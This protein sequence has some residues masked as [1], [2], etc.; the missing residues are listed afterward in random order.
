M[1]FVLCFRGHIA[2]FQCIFHVFSFLLP[3]SFTDTGLL[4]DTQNCGLCMCREYRE[5]F[6]R[7]RL[8]RK[9]LLS[10][11]GI[12]NGTCVTRV[13]WCMSRLLTRSGG[14]NVP[15]IPGACAT[16]Y[17]T[18]LARGPLDQPCDDHSVSEVNLQDITVNI[19]ASVM[20][21]PESWPMPLIRRC[22]LLIQICGFLSEI[23]VSNGIMW[24]IHWYPSCAPFTIMVYL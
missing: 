11:P 22:I 7:Q 3:A 6:P 13:P 18:Y 4:P 9:P 5:R 15:G 1:L 8:Q 14:E 21:S 16:R 17:F 19:S 2:I 24:Y 12:H 20:T 23:I 10:D